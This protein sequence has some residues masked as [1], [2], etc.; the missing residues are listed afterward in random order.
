MS[1]R[2]KTA[3][4][5]PDLHLTLCLTVERAALPARYVAYVIIAPLFMFGYIPGSYL[6]LAI[7]TVIVGL[8]NAFAHWVLW[9]GRYHLF[10]TRANFVIYLA[11]ACLV[12]YFSGAETSEGYVLYH[13]LILGFAAYSPRR[14]QV[15]GVGVLCCLGFAG[16]ILVEWFVA[17]I[18]MPFGIIM[19]KFVFLL[20]AT[21]LVATLS[22]RL[23]RME[24]QSL[25]RTQELAG[26]EATLRTILDSVDD[27][28][29]VYDDS[30]F[31]TDANDQACKLFGMDRDK[32]VGQRV[33]R[34]F[35]D[36]GTLPQKLAVVRARGVGH[37]E[38]MV[39]DTADDEHMV[40]V[41]IRSYIKDDRRYYVGI[42][43]DVTDAKDLQEATRQANEHLARINEELRQA[44]DIKTR[45]WAT[46]SR[47]LRSPLSAVLGN[48]EMLIEEELGDVS[49][50]QRKALH[51]CRRATLRSF[52][53]VDNAVTFPLPEQETPP[54]DAEDK[55]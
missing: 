13:I 49:A 21:W 18:E 30:E 34:F 15:L 45:F 12:T 6:D 27:A 46:I 20:A 3:G 55:P 40:D 16:V 1:V 47:R 24:E 52:R 23:R 9:S 5:E 37:G 35:F 22:D 50:A 8:H 26:S 48:L 4:V 25:A 7:I 2:D 10:F 38:E 19:A 32:I 54:D 44:N 28:L 42:L 11:E 14:R 43:H 51:A 36:D 29:V 53:L 31:I 17:G 39:V 33:R 41:V